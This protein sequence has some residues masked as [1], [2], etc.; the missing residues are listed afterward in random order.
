MQ[1]DAVG[2]PVTYH[3]GIASSQETT[4]ETPSALLRRLR[5]APKAGLRHA[6]AMLAGDAKKRRCCS[7]FRLW[8]DKALYASGLER[9]GVH[10]FGAQGCAGKQLTR[11]KRLS[12][13]GQV[14]STLCW[15]YALA[16][17]RHVPK[18]LQ[19]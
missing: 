11:E 7:S 12:M 3:F 15:P 5:C 19:Y 18:L 17:R 6:I 4:S 9:Q 8:V 14:N 16:T 13:I 1:H 10:E 2:D